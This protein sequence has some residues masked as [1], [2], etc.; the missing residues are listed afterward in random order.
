MHFDDL[1]IGEEEILCVHVEI[2]FKFSLKLA[3]DVS[4]F[5]SDF[6]L[7]TLFNKWNMRSFGARDNKPRGKSII[8]KLIMDTIRA[9]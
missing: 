8:C 9:I 2:N 3:N 6:D 4:S 7:R 5:N 1:R